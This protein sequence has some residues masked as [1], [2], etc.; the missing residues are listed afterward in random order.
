MKKI[1]GFFINYGGLFFC[2]I[3][4]LFLISV[5]AY[6]SPIMAGT[7]LVVALV[8]AWDGF[9]LTKLIDSFL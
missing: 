1:L 2:S 3:I 4:M 6:A 9:G 5:L 7:L 8:A